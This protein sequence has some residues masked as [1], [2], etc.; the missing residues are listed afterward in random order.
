[1]PLT[2]SQFWKV[3]VVP[4]GQTSGS[5]AFTVPTVVPISIF[6]LIWN[7]WSLPTIGDKSLIGFTLIVIFTTLENSFPSDTFKPNV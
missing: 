4:V 2:I 1:M 3:V 5:V 7:V 6:S